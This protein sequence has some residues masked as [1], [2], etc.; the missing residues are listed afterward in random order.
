MPWRPPPGAAGPGLPR[1][2]TALEC[3]PRAIDAV[4][5]GRSISTQ[6]KKS[7]RGSDAGT[8]RPSLF[9]SSPFDGTSG[10]WH[11]SAND[12]VPV[13]ASLQ[14]KS[15]FVFVDRATCEAASGLQKANCGG[16]GAASAKAVVINF[17]AARSSRLSPVRRVGAAEPRQRLDARAPRRQLGR[18]QF[19]GAQP[20]NALQLHAEE[21]RDVRVQGKIGRGERSGEIRAA[22]ASR[23]EPEFVGHRRA[24]GIQRRRVLLVRLLEGLVEDL[25]D[26]GVDI[27]V[28]LGNQPANQATL[29]GV[30]RKQRL[31]AAGIGLVEVLD[32]RIRLV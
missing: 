4:V 7:T 8:T 32:D 14:A 15:G 29:L 1:G 11:R 19:L 23:V 18:Q 5:R 6:W 10:S 20:G 12:S 30:A 2:V 21:K 26:R 27:V 24:A 16:M 31:A 9:T 13:G 3:A 25:V 22:K 17:I 28:H